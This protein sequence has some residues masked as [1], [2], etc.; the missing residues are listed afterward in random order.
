MNSTADQLFLQKRFIAGLACCLLITLSVLNLFAVPANPNLIT[1]LQPDG[2]VISYFIK[3][4]E[5]VHWM[6]STDGYT[7]LR[8]EQ[9]WVVYA[10]KDADDRLSPSSFLYGDKNA[11]RSDALTR[12]LEQTPKDLR[13]SPAQVQTLSQIRKMTQNEIQKI[14]VTGAKKALCIL[15]NFADKNIVYPIND[16]ENLMNQ[17]GYSAN[18]ASGSVKDFYLE[19]SY[20]KMDLTVTVV[21]PYTLPDT[22]GYYGENA[23][24]WKESR[25]SMFA[26]TVAQ[27]ADGDVDFKEFA[28]ANNELETF[29]IL[30]AGYGDESIQNGKQI[31]SHQSQVGKN[32]I[33]D[34]IKLS[35]YSCSPELYGSSGN[36]LTTIGVICHELCHVF[37]APDYYD[38]N[39]EGS[40][41]VYPGTGRWDLMADGSWN[42]NG[43]KRDGSQPAHINMFQ[44]ILYGWAT[45]VELND[46]KSITD[47]PNSAQNPVAYKIKP[48]TNDEMYILENRQ[49]TGFDASLPGNGLLIYHIHNSAATGNVDNTKHPQQAYVVSASSS[50]AIPSNAGSYGTVNSVRTPYPNAT[51]KD[52]FSGVSVPRMFRW[53]GNTGV[54][55][56]DKPLTDI[57]QS[58]GLIS[59]NFSCLPVQNLSAVSND[60][61]ITLSW[62]APANADGKDY[63]YTVYS[64]GTSVAE[65]IAVTSFDFLRAV[66]D[67]VYRFAVQ[68][69]VGE[70]QSKTVEL[71]FSDLSSKIRPVASQTIRLSPNPVKDFFTID[72]SGEVAVVSVRNANGQQVYANAHWM[73][74]PIP[75]SQWTK[76]VYFVRVQTL[77][78][79]RVIKT[80]KM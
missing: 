16:F 26:E 32:F 59:F 75:V 79:T 67:S 12:F 35:R 58:D 21:G 50:Y 39:Y 41:G 71:T 40:G 20:G 37:G 57:S 62:D 42:G 13:Y 53:E 25:W 31:W 4:D 28:N 18:G 46:P 64:G 1:A 8:N 77:N 23:P 65:D 66:T 70:C 33:L 10:M 7:L 52:A 44:K 73:G 51:G 56:T 45:P 30:F 9:Q 19:N 54:A 11:L 69:R 60:E 72:T 3:G 55:V 61:I 47:M 34:G 6:Q 76:G 74:E 78:E 5:Y 48:Y 2:T 17:V 38:T 43:N 68:A 14:S 29:H 22:V 49:K 80:I 27:A 63:R 24:G 36:R 15:A